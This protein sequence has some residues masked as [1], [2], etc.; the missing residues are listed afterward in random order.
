VGPVFLAYLKDRRPEAALTFQT[1][2]P[3]GMR[4]AL[5]NRWRT[6]EGQLTAAQMHTWLWE[7]WATDSAPLPQKGLGRLGSLWP[8]AAPWLRSLPVPERLA[9]LEALQEAQVPA[10]AQPRL[11]A[12]LARDEATDA[13][14]LLAVRTRLFRGELPEALALVD[15]MLAELR[16]GLGFALALPDPEP[17]A[18][19]EA[20]ED[21]VQAPSGLRAGSEPM[22]DRLRAWLAPFRDARRAGSVEEAFRKLLKERREDGTVSTGAWTLALTLTPASERPGLLQALEAAWFRGELAPDQAGPLAATLAEV[23]PPEAP[24]WLSRWPRGLSCA[25]ARGRAVI[26]ARLKDQGGAA[27]VLFD[28]RRRTLWPLHDELLAFDHWRRLGG[29]AAPGDPPPAYWSGA[30]PYWL[31]KPALPLG[32]RLK[33]H[34]QDLLAARSLLR[35]LAPLDPATAFRA[36]LALGSGR[37]GDLD[38]LRLKTARDLGG[39]SWRAAS[40]ALGPLGV[41]GALRLMVE[42]RFKTADLNQTLGDLARFAAQAGDDAR[43]QAALERLA[44]RGAPNLKAL[45]AGLALAAPA[46]QET[47]RMVDGK[48]R[49]LRPRDLTWPLLAQ[50]LKAE[51]KP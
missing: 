5:A 11:L 29:P 23:A 31:G 22:V 24:R 32:E 44:E 17:A 26:L 10:A 38:L 8:Y 15:A 27:R 48:P 28:T 43:V 3:V 18:P 7:L 36:A 13:K 33:A 25:E 37:E 6:R 9:A 14:R 34:P 35:S 4:T 42:R 47:F 12:L 16:G 45:R 21:A 51:A 19:E 40:A 2:D 49:P 1:A 39:R 20:G 50:V 30:L 41:D 46:R